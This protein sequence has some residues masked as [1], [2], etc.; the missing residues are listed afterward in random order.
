MS[1]NIVEPVVECMVDSCKILVKC[2]GKVLGGNT[3]DFKLLF[4]EIGL[5]NK[6]EEYPKLITY[7]KLENITTYLFKVPVGVSLKDFEDK[8]EKIAFFI[9][10]DTENLRL[11]RKGYNIE[12]K[13]LTSK[14]KAVYD[15]GE[16]KMKKFKIPIGIELD[17]LKIRYWDL[18]DPANA[19][20]YVAGTSRCG[21]STL[22]RLIITQL[23]QRSIADVQ[24]SL[25]NIKRVDLNEFKDC[26]NTLHYTEEDDEASDI[27]LENIKEMKR[28]YIVF[29]EYK[30]IK[31]IWRYR[32][33]VSKMP[34]RMI[35]I[36]EIAGFEKD[37]EFHANLRLLAQQGAGAGIFL[38]L[39]T[40][41]PNKDVLPNLTKQNINTVFGGKCKDSIRS[42]I[43]I[44]DGELNKLKGKGHMKV[45][46]C[47]DYG[48]EIQV[49][50]ID[51][52]IVESIAQQNIK[53]SLKNKRAAV[54]G[55]TTTLGDNKNFEKPL[56]SP[57]L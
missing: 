19:H 33:K 34:I 27:L 14:P 6:S 1:E 18:A 31:D 28:R 11:T 43:I 9:G 48:T 50:W 26:K 8:L 44:E 56:L 57:K 46:D 21:K 16:Y 10:E 54:A 17:T 51:D 32:D 24:L 47:D 15:P 37:N 36:E 38:L 22:I 41:L 2:I 7:K 5:Q 3:H 49:L 30:G 40:Q 52:D 12:L 45:F 25:I 42:D 53:I 4:K 13:I 35:V 23:I 55:T 39:A 29:N 20:S